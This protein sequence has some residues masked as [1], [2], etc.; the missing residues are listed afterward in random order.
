LSADGGLARAI[1]VAAC[2][3]PVPHRQNDDV[4]LR[5]DR[6]VFRIPRGYLKDA[7]D[8]EDG[9]EKFFTIKAVL[10]DLSPVPPIPGF[11]TGPHLG[12]G[13]S[14]IISVHYGLRLPPQKEAIKTLLA[15]TKTDESKYETT[16]SGFRKYSLGS[17]DIF[18]KDNIGDT[19]F[20][21]ACNPDEP[22]SS[23]KICS[24]HENYQNSF[25][26]EY[27]IDRDR[28]DDSFNIDVKV[29]CLLD[30]FRVNQN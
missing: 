10:P 18:I 23:P 22:K 29:H 4:I 26:M 20:Y 25:S 13:T 15:A 30:S 9:R 19:F 24:V 12:L 6:T 7:N 2:P 8:A 21:L 1:D 11:G 28:Q 3:N 5:F 27:Y 17:E 16:K 14:I